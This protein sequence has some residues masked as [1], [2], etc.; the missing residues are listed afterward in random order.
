MRRAFPAPPLSATKVVAQAL[1][2]RRQLATNFVPM[3]IKCAG[4]HWRACKAS[5][6]L[7]V[8]GFAGASVMR[9]N[10]DCVR[11]AA[12]ALIAAILAFAPVQAEAQRAERLDGQD[13]ASPFMR[14]HGTT[15]PP[16]GFVGF[17][18]RTP[19]ECDRGPLEESRFVLTPGRLA[20][21]DDVNRTVNRTIEPATD[22]EIYGKVEYWT[23]PTTRGDCEDYAL[24]KRHRLIANGW[25]ASALLITV[26]RDEKAEGHAILTARTAQGDFLLDNKTDEIKLW[27]RSTYTFVMRQSYL[28]PKL[29]MSLD[30]MD[31]TSPTLLSGVRQRR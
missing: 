30:P 31:A 29:W 7:S 22:L 16:F 4:A 21:L 6:V 17:C 2:R 15:Q 1:M 24:L 25:P 26:V 8:H 20:E 12:T 28:D 19:S 11:V 3:P 9:S 27:S 14:T 18:D 23:L 10:L 5:R 13:R